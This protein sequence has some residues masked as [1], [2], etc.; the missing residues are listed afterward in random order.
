M[1]SL[2]VISAAVGLNRL[3]MLSEMVEHFVTSARESTSLAN[4][5]LQLMNEQT[6]DTL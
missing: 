3:A 2:L 4:R 5:T 1:L 6:Q